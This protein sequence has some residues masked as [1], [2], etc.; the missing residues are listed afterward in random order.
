MTIYVL[1]ASVIDKNK[2]TILAQLPKEKAEQIMAIRNER[3]RSLTIGSAFFKWIVLKDHP[4]TVN[5]KGKPTAGSIHFNISHS[6][7]WV[8]FAKDDSNEIGIDIE[9]KKTDQKLWEF[10]LSPE[11]LE[12]KEKTKT[13]FLNYY[14]AKESLSK[15]QGEGLTNGIKNIPAIPLNGKVCF[16]DRTFFR[17]TIIWQNNSISVTMENEDFMLST[18]DIQEI[19]EDMVFQLTKR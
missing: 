5:D 11:E 2:E 4:W 3:V 1:H 15:A 7:P 19:A 17:H 8:I 13:P 6:Y 18:D 16:K 9:N 10:C 12:D 14:T